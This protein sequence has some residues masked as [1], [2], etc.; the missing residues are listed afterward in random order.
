MA[1]KPQ[2]FTVQPPNLI[3]RPPSFTARGTTSRSTRTL[4]EGGGPVR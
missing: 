2:S 1:Q 3:A 4:Q